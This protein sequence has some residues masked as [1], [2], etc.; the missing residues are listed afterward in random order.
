MDSSPLR[1]RLMPSASTYSSGID[2]GTSKS[3]GG[4]DLGSQRTPDRRSVL[5]DGDGGEGRQRACENSFGGR[6][7]CLTTVSMNSCSSKLLLTTVC[8]GFSF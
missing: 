2:V 7:I 8:S 6:L 3:F 4:T 1:D 5:L